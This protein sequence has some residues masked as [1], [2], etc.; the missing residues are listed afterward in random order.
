MEGYLVRKDLLQALVQFP[1]RGN[2]MVEDLDNLCPLGPRQAVLQVQIPLKSVYAL[3]QKPAD[4]SSHGL[5][6]LCMSISGG[7]PPL[8]SFAQW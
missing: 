8:S 3:P 5:C 1:L 4:R 6:R 7:T 2:D